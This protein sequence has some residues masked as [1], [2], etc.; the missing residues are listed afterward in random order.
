MHL[1]AQGLTAD[2]DRQ[3]RFELMADDIAALIKH[4][5]IE[6]ADLMGYSLGGGVALQ[7]SIRHSDLVRKLMLVST[8]FKR[9]GCYPEVL[10]GMAQM[11]PVA[12]RA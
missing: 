8:P 1:Q 7:T 12:T 5:G 3:P 4:L 10:K 9:N 2:I 6:K 11:G